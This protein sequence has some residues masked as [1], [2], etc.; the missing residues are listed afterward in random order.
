MWLIVCV[1]C[2][3]SITTIHNSLSNS[4]STPNL[5]PH[6]VF[7]KSKNECWTTY[8]SLLGWSR[9]KTSMLSHERKLGWFFY[10]FD[11]SDISWYYFKLLWWNDNG[12]NLTDCVILAYTLIRD[13]MGDIIRMCNYSYEVDPWYSAW[14]WQ[15]RRNSYAQ[16]MNVV[17][18]NSKWT[19]TS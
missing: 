8:P 19:R 11:G 14:V 5:C 7:G 17:I 6:H 16:T 9:D 1:H 3:N 4:V 13:N 10:C 18:Q 12:I 15:R 2:G